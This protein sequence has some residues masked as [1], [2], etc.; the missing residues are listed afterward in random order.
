MAVH[1]RIRRNAP[2]MF[3]DP[4]CR[5]LAKPLQRIACA[6]LPDLN[7]RFNVRSNSDPCGSGGASTIEKG[8]PTSVK[9]PAPLHRQF[10][11]LFG[12]A[13]GQE[14]GKPGPGS[15]SQLS[16]QSK[17]FIL[18]LHRCD[19][20]R[21]VISDPLVFA[22]VSRTHRKSQCSLNEPVSKTCKSL[23]DSMLEPDIDRSSAAILFVGF[24]GLSY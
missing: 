14:K 15:Q 4:P 20:N 16:S 10:G 13:K 6:S 12:A 3:N 22:R 18:P 23:R 11:C 8:P 5:S 21:V 1:Y 19:V 2:P 7:G 24:A 17:C 9:E